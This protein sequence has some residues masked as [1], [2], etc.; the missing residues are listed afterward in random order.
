MS[1]SPSEPT[2]GLPCAAAPVFLTHRTFST[3]ESPSVFT[4]PID[5][6]PRAAPS[7]TPLAALKPAHDIAADD[8]LTAAVPALVELQRRVGN[9]F[10]LRQMPTPS[11]FGVAAGRAVASWS[12]APG[13]HA[14]SFAGSGAA[15]ANAATPM[16]WTPAEAS[17]QARWPS[18]T[19][20]SAA[21]T[22]GPH[23]ST[24]STP[25]AQQGTP[26]SP[27]RALP[28]PPSR[29]AE[30][31]DGSAKALMRQSTVPWQRKGH[32]RLFSETA[33]SSQPPLYRKH[34]SDAQNKLP[35]AYTFTPPDIPAGTA[36]PFSSQTPSAPQSIH[37]GSLRHIGR[38]P[39]AAQQ[40]HLTKARSTVLPTQRQL[41]DGGDNDTLDS[42]GQQ[43]LLALSTLGE[44][45]APATLCSGLASQPMPP[46]QQ[47]PTSQPYR[48]TKGAGAHTRAHVAAEE[49]LMNGHLS[50]PI[51]ANALCR[52]FGQYI[53]AQRALKP[54][55]L[56]QLNGASGELTVP[57]QLQEL[58]L[59]QVQGFASQLDAAA[60]LPVVPHQRALAAATEASHSSPGARQEP[61]LVVH[62][63]H[64]SDDIAWDAI[65]NYLDSP[66]VTRAALRAVAPAPRR[67]L[68]QRGWQWMMTKMAR[69][70]CPFIW[71]NGPETNMRDAY[72]R[73]DGRERQ[74]V[75]SV[76]VARL[77]PQLPPHRPASAM[78]ERLLDGSALLDCQRQSLLLDWAWREGWLHSLACSHHTYVLPRLS[79]R[80]NVTPRIRV[81]GIACDVLRPM[82]NRLDGTGGREGIS[83]RAFTASEGAV[84]ISALGANDSRLTPPSTPMPEAQPTEAL[85]ATRKLLDSAVRTISRES[86]R[87]ADV[88]LSAQPYAK[89]ALYSMPA[90]AVAGSSIF[91]A[92]VD[93]PII[94]PPREAERRG[95]LGPNT[96]LQHHPHYGHASL[97]VLVEDVSGAA[98]LL[99]T[100]KTRL[101][102]EEVWRWT[103]AW[104]Q[105]RHR[106][107]RQPICTSAAEFLL[108]RSPSAPPRAVN[109]EIDYFVCTT[110]AAVAASPA[111]GACRMGHVT[112][113]LPG[114]EDGAAASPP[115]LPDSAISPEDDWAEENCGAAMTKLASAE[116]GS[117][118]STG[119][120]SGKGLV[121]VAAVGEVGHAGSG[122][123]VESHLR[124]RLQE[125]RN[126]RC[127]VVR[128]MNDIDPPWRMLGNASGPQPRPLALHLTEQH[129]PWLAQQLCPDSEGGGLVDLQELHLSVTESLLP[130][131]WA[132]SWRWC[133]SVLRDRKN[134]LVLNVA[135]QPSTP[136]TS[137]GAAPDVNADGPPHD[138]TEVIE[139]LGASTT[140][141][142]MLTAPLQVLSLQGAVA[143]AVAP[144]FCDV[145]REARVEGDEDEVPPAL[146]RLRELYV[147][148]RG[149]ERAGGSLRSAGLG[150]IH[151]TAT[152]YPAL[153][154][155]WLDVPRLRRI[156]I[157]RFLVLRELHLVSDVPLACSA[158]RGVERLPHLEVLH[159]E[160]AIIDD[161]SFFGNCPALR[162]LLLHACRLSLLLPSSAIV[163]RS[164]VERAEELRGVERAPHLET[165]SLCYTEEV[166]NLQNFARCHS[167]RR[168]ILTRCNGISSSS[169][170]GLE[171]LP[172]LEWLAMEYTRVSALSQFAETPALRVLRVDGC[173]RVLH[174]SVMG[175]E[176]AALL[177][178]LLLRET[179]VSTVANF[180]GGCRALRSLDLSGCRHLDVDGLQGIQALPQLEILSLSHTSITDVDFLADCVRLTTLY[181]E[182]CTKLLPTSLEGL[183]HAPKLCK[184]VANGCPTLTR[185]GRLGKCASLEVF[186]VA[187]AAAL[188]AEGVQGIEQGRRVRYLDLSSTA[189]STLSFLAGGCRALRYLSVK[190]CQRITT[191]SALEGV[192]K[193]PRLRVLNMESLTLHGRL[194]F[195]AT[196][197]S[198]RFVS[199][200]GCTG[201][202]TDDVQALHQSGVQSVIP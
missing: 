108:V 57:L 34:L 3:P 177:T 196:S 21:A 16:S 120:A 201:L 144:L 174:S 182:G 76:S 79:G 169:V 17:L 149:Y 107:P 194:D 64:R 8:L 71:E 111:A 123:P 176:T 83:S 125:W 22:L 118:S 59:R 2:H 156:H 86:A 1:T 18:R 180:G 26:G 38:A 197:T 89:V 127:D 131:G 11:S 202:S 12:I 62:A 119:K 139:V 33:H 106:L 97:P 45:Y 160:K 124:V 165:L 32:R 135:V 91:T 190:A 191:T 152:V 126:K 151:V 25:C 43:S 85:S 23:K 19:P 72:A 175:L 188:G 63:A 44:S 98:H 75:G 170:A 36:S 29:E 198:L 150:D 142:A 103:S 50:P 84:G 65:I 167:L 69:D 148:V 138:L 35:T 114:A 94:R 183:Q 37:K 172:R 122:A 112:G 13:S 178:E 100:R 133:V 134:L 192:E 121:R 10:S 199:Y 200:A 47:A 4:A 30:Q 109:D 137:E 184:L 136:L 99:C 96:A 27:A 52:L 77:A 155:L 110:A 82:G 20:L 193:L 181:L 87:S 115:L 56:Q 6:S 102:R 168:I 41:R 81:D 129:I 116:D 101:D 78:K 67:R 15:A 49:V 68:E 5:A 7:L 186:A 95:S 163:P 74:Y 128:R 187:G 66:N 140:R 70:V 171:H 147:S 73:L 159:L 60:Y 39:T 46:P 117:M 24:A 141:A 162:E 164:G 28:A 161:C 54:A 166:R 14:T 153:Q 90:R 31:G 9:E 104:L 145:N 42:T 88:T 179:N 80:G 40:L 113:T 130:P 158:L 143:E 48:V 61:P 132:A 92:S 146:E 173:K 58:V 185:V 157:D 51:P 189:V 105:H 93:I 154:V 55:V 195:L 53:N